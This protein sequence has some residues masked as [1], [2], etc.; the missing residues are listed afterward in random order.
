MTMIDPAYM[1]KVHD[2]LATAIRTLRDASEDYNEPIAVWRAARGEAGKTAWAWWARQIR[3][4]EDG[5]YQNF[6]PTRE[7][8][9]AWARKEYGPA[10][11]FEI[12][13]A[14]QWNDD[15]EGDEICF[16]AE[17]RGLEFISPEKLG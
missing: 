3:F 9:I 7:A 4:D 12:C 6:E 2:A 8:I 17:S 16:F 11:R 14:R 5:L 13:E 10:A 1:G 15:L